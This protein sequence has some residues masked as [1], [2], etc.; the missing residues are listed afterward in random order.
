MYS[1]YP[2]RVLSINS[3]NDPLS[4]SSERKRS[5]AK[6]VK[7][8]WKNEKKK[9]GAR[10]RKEQ[11]QE[12]TVL[13]VSLELSSSLRAPQ[14]G[15]GRGTEDRGCGRGRGGGR[16]GGKEFEEAESKGRRKEERD[17]GRGRGGGREGVKEVEEEESEGRSKEQRGTGGGGRGRRS[18]A[19]LGA[20][21]VP[22]AV[23]RGKQAREREWEGCGGA[24]GGVTHT[25]LHVL[26]RREKKILK[27]HNSWIERETKFK[28]IL[29]FL[30]LV[31]LDT[32]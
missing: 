18:C 3:T 32:H 19:G 8:K 17:G 4:E 22:G 14:E 31:G 23:A 27:I 5:S 20:A 21:A 1:R 13:H 7:I 15:G 28:V 10:R 30:L 6:R 2:R 24:R 26:T 25:H 11:V 12:Y 9:D 16:G 29:F